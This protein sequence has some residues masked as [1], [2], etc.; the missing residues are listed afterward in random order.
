[1][2]RLLCLVSVAVVLSAVAWRPVAAAEEAKDAQEVKEEKLRVLVVTGGHGFDKKPF[3]A[4]FD[5]NKDITY[6][7]ARHPAAA[8]LL[9]PELAEKQDVIVFYDQPK[10]FKPEQQKAFVE[11]L[12]KGIGVVA[13]HHTLASH[14]NWPE[15]RKIIGGQYF[16]KKATIDGKEYPKSN[17]AHG[18]DINVKIADAAHPI[19]QGLKDFAIHDETYGRYYVDPT[20]RVLLTTDNP[21]SEPQLAWVKTY[22]ASRVCYLLLGHDK[23][24]YENENYRQLIARAIRWSAGRPADPAAAMTPLFNGK[25]LTGWKAEGKAVWEVKDGMLIG[26]Q[27]NRGAPG[28]LFTEKSFDDFELKVTFKVVWPANS[29][30]WYRYQ[31]G[32]KTYQAD[33]L[34]Y[35]K[36]VAFTGTIYCPGKMFIAINADKSLVNRE[37]FNTMLIRAA[38]NRHVVFL[39]GKKVA[40]ARDDLSK[41]G[42][43]GFQVHAGRRYKG[44]QII[45]KEI[46][47]R[48]I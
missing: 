7:K 9:E 10:K 39:N 29:G 27:G 15:Y 48:G 45:V 13:L 14:G 31:A 17:Y 41:T 40:D 28:D 3:F 20:A 36:P 24:A 23:H 47:I 43:I 44:M 33:I 8:K 42:K 32:N 37:G 35:K 34:E 21:K 19:T 26:R 1:M 16:F 25:D 30:V 11:M 5:Q 38:G 46:G 22:G 2:K 6:T 12:D 18:L 4:I